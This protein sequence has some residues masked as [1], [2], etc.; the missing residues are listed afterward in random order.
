MASTYP[1]PDAA[2]I[3]VMLGCLFDGL[4]VKPGKKFDITPRRPPQLPSPVAGGKSLT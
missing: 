1:L 3:K 4:E 2:K